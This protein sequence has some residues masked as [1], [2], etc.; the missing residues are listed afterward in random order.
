MLG[1]VVERP[2]LSNSTHTRT[3]NCA[4]PTVSRPVLEDFSLQRQTSLQRP[5]WDFESRPADSNRFPISLSVP[6]YEPSNSVG[7]NTPSAPPLERPLFLPSYDQV[8]NQSNY[9]IEEE[10][11]P[12][13]DEIILKINSNLWPKVLILAENQN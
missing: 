1:S 6:F 9:E 5:C 4:I 13:Y 3:N 10:P 8:I 2:Y 12:T 7:A 11:P